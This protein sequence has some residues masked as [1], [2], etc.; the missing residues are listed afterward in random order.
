MNTFIKDYNNNKEEYLKIFKEIRKKRLEKL[1]GFTGYNYYAKI[2][3][4]KRGGEW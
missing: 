4:M 3:E 1:K 2:H